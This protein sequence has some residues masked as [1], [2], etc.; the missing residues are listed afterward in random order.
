MCSGLSVMQKIVKDLFRKFGFNIKYTG[1]RSRLLKDRNNRTFKKYVEFI[2][3]SGSG[4]TTVLNEVKN[5]IKEDWLFRQDLRRIPINLNGNDFDSEAHSKILFAKSKYLED[6]G[7]TV[8]QKTRLLRYFAKIILFDLKM[9]KGNAQKGF[10]L[11][12]GIFHNFPE[13]LLGLNDR[14]FKNLVSGRNLILIKPEN[15]VTVVEHLKNRKNETGRV[16]IPHSGLSDDALLL[17]I[18]RNVSIFN[19][20]AKRA[21]SCGTAVVHLIME[22]GIKYNAQIVAAFEENLNRKTHP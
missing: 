7:L 10:F 19:R 9:L 22:D 3:P 6:S 13:E 4:K 5:N 15:G 14:E 17:N 18:N 16:A 1:S 2:G 21:E 8:Y 12:E 20:L 11:D